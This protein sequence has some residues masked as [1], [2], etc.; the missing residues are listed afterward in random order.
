MQFIGYILVYSFFWL[1]H[2]LPERILAGVSGFFYGV[3]YYIARYRRKVVYGNLSRAFPELGP[4]ERTKIAKKYY[5]HL[6]DLFLESAISHFDSDRQFLR[7]ISFRNLEVLDAAFSKGKQVIGVTAHYGNWEFL[8]TLGALTGFRVMGAYKPIKNKYIDRMVKR[9]RERFNSL[10]VPMGQIARAMM[11]HQRDGV[12]A[13]S[14]FVAD[15]SPIFS[16]IQYWTK[17][18]GQDT[19]LYLGAEKLARKLDATVVFLKVRKTRRFRYEVEIEMITEEPGKMEPFGITEA[20]VRILESLIKE[21]PEFWLW[22]HRRWKHS[23]EKLH[24][25]S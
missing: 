7:R 11:E 5:R 25:A 9:S 16:Q 17:F 13:V 6:S 18:L 1:L 22:S 14:I 4:G 8:T 23:Y 12:P 2:L 19:P 10:P 21:R 15:Q 20:H 3:I 24:T